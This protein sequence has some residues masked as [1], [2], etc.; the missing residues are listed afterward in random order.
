MFIRALLISVWNTWTSKLVDCS[1]SLET[2]LPWLYQ[3]IH[4]SAD[5]S[6]PSLAHHA[7][8]G[9]ISAVH[10]CRRTA[11][12]AFSADV[13]VK[14]S[15][16]PAVSSPAVVNEEKADSFE[17][18]I[19]DMNYSISSY[20][21]GESYILVDNESLVDGRYDAPLPRRPV[22]VTDVP[23]QNDGKSSSYNFYL[24]PVMRT[25]GRVR[26][27]LPFEKSAPPAVKPNLN[28]VS[29][30]ALISSTE[31]LVHA[32]KRA[33]STTC[34]LNRLEELSVHLMKNPET[35]G[36]AV[37]VSGELPCI[38]SGCRNVSKVN[39]AEVEPSPNSV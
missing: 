12:R 2:G 1:A 3:A 21:A 6:R 25:V 16:H 4:H 28:L 37:K 11:T 34:L 20:H 31:G 32:A 24:E 36:I 18:S 33:E 38:N 35:N 13:T 8:P 19:D 39:S 14:G 15:K 27:I 7:R 22:P 9:D 30:G 29:K 23:I 5:R 26:D 10:D 17:Q